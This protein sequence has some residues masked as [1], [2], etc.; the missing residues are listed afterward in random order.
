MFAEAITN[1]AVSLAT[2]LGSPLGWYNDQQGEIGALCGGFG[3]PMPNSN[4]SE[5]YMV[6]KVWSNVY[7]DC[8]VEVPVQKS[9][10]I[11]PSPTTVSTT[12]KSPDL[13]VPDVVFVKGG[14]HV[15][16]MYALSYFGGPL[17]SSVEVSPIFWGQNTQFQSELEEFYKFLVDS[18]FMDIMTQ[19]GTKEY[20]IQKGTYITSHIIQ[21][22]SSKE[23]KPIDDVM[24][25][26]SMLRE[27][28]IS[29][30]IKPTLNSYFPIHFAPNT[31]ITHYNQQSCV[32]FC[33]YHSV[34]NITD[35]SP[36]AKY[37]F[38]G[39]IADQ[40][41]DSECYSSCGASDAFGNSCSIA[42]HELAEAVT[43]PVVFDKFTGW[44]GRSGEIADACNQQQYKYG[45]W[46]IQKLWSNSNNRC[47]K[48]NVTAI[49]TS[50][51]SANAVSSATI[52]D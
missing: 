37:L 13:V 21:V 50:A 35:I 10:T 23:K 44:F 27:L 51:Q 26:Q 48:M 28:V 52:V 45:S 36:K 24:D 19:Y 34:V 42:S 2:S 3:Y 9:V 1:P 17:I 12:T 33:G 18:P 7:E 14:L 25:I 16:P 38:Y 41:E 20:P 11:R 47:M 32:D 15:D 30:T 6:Q 4:G 43:D 29:G 40:S 8:I 49:T 22:D 39:V 46:T 5:T 31:N